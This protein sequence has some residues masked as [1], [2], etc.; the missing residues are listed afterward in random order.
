MWSFNKIK[1]KNYEV[2]TSYV[3]LFYL[4][5]IKKNDIFLQKN[6]LITSSFFKKKNFLFTYLF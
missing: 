6:D 2:I 4:F 5:F 3:V 1:N